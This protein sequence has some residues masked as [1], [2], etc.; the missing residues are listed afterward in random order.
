M[1]SHLWGII[2]QSQQSSENMVGGQIHSMPC[3]ERDKYLDEKKYTV[4]EAVTNKPIIGTCQDM[5]LKWLHATQYTNKDCESAEKVCDLLF[6]PLTVW[7]WL[8][9][10]T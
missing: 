1:L 8:N 4:H 10:F 5:L 2:G 9:F 6:N 7:M 3:Y